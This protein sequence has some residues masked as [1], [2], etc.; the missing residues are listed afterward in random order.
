MRNTQKDKALP[1]AYKDVEQFYGSYAGFDISGLVRA[2]ATTA[3]LRVPPVPLLSG[4]GVCSQAA[5]PEPPGAG[6]GPAAG[7]GSLLFALGLLPAPRDGCGLGRKAKPNRAVA[8]ATRRHDTPRRGCYATQPGSASAFPEV[9]AT[10]GARQH[11]GAGAVS[12][13]RCRCSL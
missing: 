1:S 8:M 13:L 3:S 4:G 7:K 5:V 9:L 6:A 11:G 10:S 12:A 2:P